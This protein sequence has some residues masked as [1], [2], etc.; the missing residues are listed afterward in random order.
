MSRVLAPNCTMYRVESSFASIFVTLHWTRSEPLQSLI[1]ILMHALRSRRNDKAFHNNARAVRTDSKVYN[2]CNA[3]THAQ[4]SVG[5]FS[6]RAVHRSWDDLYGPTVNIWRSKAN[7]N[8][9]RDTLSVSIWRSHSGHTDTLVQHPLC[10]RHKKPFWLPGLG[11]ILILMIT[12]PAAPWL[13][14]NHSRFWNT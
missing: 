14:N 2:T 5:H 4:C 13:S 3:L 9:L 1:L 8:K 11:F 7:F 10:L 12:V 6:E